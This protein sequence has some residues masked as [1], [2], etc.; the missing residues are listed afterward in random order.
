MLQVSERGAS[1]K[2]TLA[3]PVNRSDYSD[4][5]EHIVRNGK[6]IGIDP[7]FITRFARQFVSLKRKRNGR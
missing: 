2:L 1:F 3:R 6:R 4:V 5:Y 7:K